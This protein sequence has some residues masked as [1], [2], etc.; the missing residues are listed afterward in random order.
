LV[1][2]SSLLAHRGQRVVHGGV[3]A[4][5]EALAFGHYW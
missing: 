4:Q 1:L 5:Q 2:R 3:E